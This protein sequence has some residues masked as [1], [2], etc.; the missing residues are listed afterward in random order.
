MA[1]THAVC[2]TRRLTCKVLFLRAA[3]RAAVPLRDLA[4]MLIGPGMTKL[5]VETVTPSFNNAPMLQQQPN[6]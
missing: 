1:R 3:M 6:E 2:S 4:L 5:L